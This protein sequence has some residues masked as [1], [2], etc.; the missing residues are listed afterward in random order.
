[1]SGFTQDIE[2]TK[3]GQIVI[4]KN[5]Q[6]ETRSRGFDLQP[7]I[8]TDDFVGTENTSKSIAALGKER[9][10]GLKHVKAGESGFQEPFH[11]A[12]YE[13]SSDVESSQLKLASDTSDVHR[14]TAGGREFDLEPAANASGFSLQPVAEGSGLGIKSSIRS[15]P[16]SVSSIVVEERGFDLQPAQAGHGF[17]LQPIVNLLQGGREEV[18]TQGEGEDDEEDMPPLE[19]LQSIKSIVRARKSA[20]RESDRK[21][22]AANTSVKKGPKVTKEKSS[23][24][25]SPEKPPQRKEKRKPASNVVGKSNLFKPSPS[26]APSWSPTPTMRDSKTK[27]RHR[28][29][30]AAMIDGLASNE[31]LVPFRWSRETP[32]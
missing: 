18:Q 21:G 27:V 22:S 8:V 9:D 31:S 23:K 13:P 32:P 10:F 28:V 4:E 25:G 29:T 2:Q 14:R 11:D 30:A 6:G 3:Q 19:S 1:M 24:K 5:D 16:D 17:S 7:V 15:N 12:S 20:G 26:S